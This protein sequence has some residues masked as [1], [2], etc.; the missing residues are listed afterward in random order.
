MMAC[1]P[2][3]ALIAAYPIGAGGASRVQK[4][5]HDAARPFACFHLLDGGVKVGLEL[6]KM[7]A[8]VPHDAG[9]GDLVPIGSLDLDDDQHLL[10]AVHLDSQVN[11]SAA[12][13]NWPPSAFGG[14]ESASK[15]KKE[16]RLNGPVERLACGKPLYRH[17]FSSR[18]LVITKR[19][20]ALPC[21]PER[22][23]PGQLP[24]VAPL[25]GFAAVSHFEQCRG[26]A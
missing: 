14:S 9:R 8:E 17:E 21:S 26:G 12:A 5:S 1:S 19:F 13:R 15:P 10:A 22:C 18:P 4:C 25:L 23:G 16:C 2:A 6:A 11:S 20:S 7:T 3:S 24:P